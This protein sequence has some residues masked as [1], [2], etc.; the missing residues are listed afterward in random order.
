LTAKQSA[1]QERWQDTTPPLHIVSAHIPELGITFGQQTVYGKSNEVPAVRELIGLLSIKGCMVVADALNCQKDTARAII[2]A[3]ADYLLNVKDNHPILKKDIEDY[4]QDDDLRQGMTSAY[5][6]EPNRGRIERRTGY[7]TNN[8][9]WLE[10][11]KDWYKL[12]CIG[13][14]NRQVETSGAKT[15]E[16]HYYICS[17]PLTAEEL[18]KHARNEW[19]VETMHWLLDV[20]FGE[21]FCRVEDEFSQQSLNIIRKIVLNFIKLYKDKI[22]S[23]RPMSRIMFDCLLD[24][25]HLSKILI[26]VQN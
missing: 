21:D 8:I 9:A 19:S 20:H 3:E 15:N 18:L 7:V 1:P 14:I 25:A 22:K 13:A 2:K 10:G 12:A 6:L 16:W 24:P 23:K 26:M 11:K 4:V 5:T 17:K